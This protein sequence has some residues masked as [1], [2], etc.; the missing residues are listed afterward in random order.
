M[1]AKRPIHASSSARS[2]ARSRRSG[3]G[4]A[5]TAARGTRS[6]KSARPRATRPSAGAH[7]YALAGPSSAGAA[8]RRH[9]DR[10]ARRGC[11]PASTS[12]IACS[13]A[14]SSRARSCCSAASRAS[15]SRRCCCRPRRTWR[16]PI[17]PVLYSS[18]EESEHQI[19]S[20]GERLASA[21]RRSIC[22]PKPASSGSSKRS[23]A[24]SRRCVIVDSIQT[25]FSLKFQSAPGSIGQ[26]REAATQLLFTAKG[27]NVPTFLV[28]H[29]TKDGSLAGPKALE[30][31]V[32]TVLYFEGERHH[33]HRV[34]R[35]VKN[36]F[37]AVSEL[38]VFEMTVGRPAAGAESV[39]A[40]SRR[41]AVERARA[42]RC[43]AR[44]RARGRFSSRCRRSSARA[45]YGNA[46]RM[47]SGIDQQRLSLLLAVLEKRAG[48][49]L[50]GDDVF[51]NIAGGMT[52][53]EPASDLGVARGDRVERPQSRDS[54]RRRRCSAKS[55]W[56]ARSAASRRRP[57]ASAKRRRWGSARCIMPEA[58]IDPADR[59]RPAVDASWSASAPSAKRSTLL[60]DCN[61][62]PD[63]HMSDMVGLQSRPPGFTFVSRRRVIHGGRLM[64][65]FAL[66]RV[67]FVAAVAYAAALLRPLP[68]GLARSTSLSALALAG[69]R[70]SCFESRLR[71]T[72]PPR[73]AR[74]AHRL[75]RSAWRSRAR[76][77]RASF[78]ADTGDRRVEFLHSF[79]LIVLP[80]LGLVLG[81]QAR[82]VAR[83]GAAGQPVPRRRARSAATRFSTPA[84]SSTAASPTSARPASSTARWSSRSSCSRSCSSSPTRPTR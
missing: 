58:N 83:A 12:S 35:A 3:S 61:L 78:W 34:V 16:A 47:A 24:S 52:V 70:A 49:N 15:A 37:G 26:V 10:A 65:W 76:S 25:V 79:L 4:A 27:Q 7:R 72:P 29:V 30:H 22:S 39:E 1:L 38:G 54:A 69:A 9:R 51:V 33:S 5:P 73:V 67:F 28:G 68:V 13:A 18:G 31:V 44:S 53:D 23:R 17:G 62:N 74:R 43:C 42:R 32:D 48:L 21:T 82:R 60:L 40:V 57:C 75:R 59:S 11:R 20:R 55:V 2:A 56:R 64:A 77:R 45:R 50:I 71:E 63:R 14:A 66:A 19:K 46:R 36:R 8:L 6:S 81:A 41:A 80:Y 84:S